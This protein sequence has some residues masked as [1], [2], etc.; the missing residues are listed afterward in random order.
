MFVNAC[1][2]SKS[3]RALFNLVLTSFEDDDVV[4]LVLREMLDD[5]ATSVDE[6]ELADGLVTGR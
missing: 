6:V 2:T 1:G 4:G 5:M 3:G